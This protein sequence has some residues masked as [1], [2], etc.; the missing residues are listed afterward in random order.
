MATA[1]TSE[2]AA[3]LGR[4]ASRMHSSNSSIH[5]IFAHTTEPSPCKEACVFEQQ[6]PSPAASIGSASP[7]GGCSTNDAADDDEGI[8]TAKSTVTGSGATVPP[9]DLS[10]VIVADATSSHLMSPVHPRVESLTEP[11]SGEAR[12]S[13]FLSDSELNRALF[14]IQEFSRDMKILLDGGL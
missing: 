9:S 6:Q 8:V 10:G 14:E 4:N 7:V 1:P 2:Q 5:K 11:C 3:T 13:P 12:S